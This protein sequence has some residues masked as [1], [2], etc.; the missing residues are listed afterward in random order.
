M[1]E[2]RKEMNLFVVGHLRKEMREN[3]I[4]EG[5]LRWQLAIIM[6]HQCDNI[7]YFMTE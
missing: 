2:S 1:R 6:N 4:R 5:N 3:E 7:R